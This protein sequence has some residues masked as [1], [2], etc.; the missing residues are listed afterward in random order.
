[1]RAKIDNSDAE[2]CLRKRYEAR[3]GRGHG[4][5]EGFGFA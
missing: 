4:L 3:G 2:F 1:M 5:G